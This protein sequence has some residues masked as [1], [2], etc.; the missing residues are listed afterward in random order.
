MSQSV[1]PNGSSDTKLQTAWWNDVWQV[2][3]K[4]EGRKE[5]SSSHDG[6]KKRDKKAATVDIVTKCLERESLGRE[7]QSACVGGGEEGW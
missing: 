5:T 2:C 6:E 7:G 1:Q 3:V 4:K